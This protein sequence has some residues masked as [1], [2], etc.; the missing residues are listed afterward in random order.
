VVSFGYKSH[1]REKRVK[2]L[3]VLGLLVWKEN[4]SIFVRLKQ[5]SLL[6]VFIFHTFGGL[7]G[8]SGGMSNSIVKMPF[9]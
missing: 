4:F 9:S 8:Y 7:K 6:F 5:I 3:S 1:L 2:G